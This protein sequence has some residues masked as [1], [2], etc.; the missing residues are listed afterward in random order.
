MTVLLRLLERILRQFLQK[1][2]E[3]ETTFHCYLCFESVVRV[4]M[5][6]CLPV[7]KKLRFLLSMKLD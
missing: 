1:I 6:S 7:W 2:G 5:L 4:M 3:E